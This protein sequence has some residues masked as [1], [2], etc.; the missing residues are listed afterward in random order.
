MRAC[1]R[2]LGRDGFEDASMIETAYDDRRR[3]GC[4]EALLGKAWVQRLS[5][6]LGENNIAQLRGTVVI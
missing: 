2:V 5:T 6:A 3:E 4:A 1:S